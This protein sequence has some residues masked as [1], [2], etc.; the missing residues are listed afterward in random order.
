MRLAVNPEFSRLDTKI[1]DKFFGKRGKQFPVKEIE[2][3]V[4]EMM[5]E[6]SVEDKPWSPGD[7]VVTEGDFLVTCCSEV[8]KKD[9]AVIDMILEFHKLYIEYMTRNLSTREKALLGNRWWDLVEKFLRRQQAAVRDLAKSLEVDVDLKAVFPPLRFVHGRGVPQ[10][11]PKKQH[12]DGDKGAAAQALLEMKGAP[13]PAVR[14]PEEG[15][16]E[17]APEDGEEEKKAG[18]A[19]AHPVKWSGG[20]PDKPDKPKP[21]TTASRAPAPAP[22]A[23]VPAP[24]P[25]AAAAA[26]V[27]APAPAA[28]VPAPAPA[29]AVPAPAPAAGAGAGAGAGEEEEEEEEGGVVP[30]FQG[31]VVGDKRQAGDQIQRPPK[32]SRGSSQVVLSALKKAGLVVFSPPSSSSSSSSFSSSSSSDDAAAFESANLLAFFTKKMV[33]AHA[34]VQGNRVV[35][36]LWGVEE[37]TLDI[38]FF[39]KVTG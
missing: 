21:S 29:P 30:Y 9:P 15:E 37:D 28:A 25:A 20:H 22:A 10:P 14:A 33:P 2:N 1:S 19:P 38:T 3:I 8:V 27:P 35:E 16:E 39:D 31:A 5:K 32:I 13:A 34:A 26:A 6:A 7:D 23:A 18:G 36:T 17:E 4:N 24:A 12:A 11:R